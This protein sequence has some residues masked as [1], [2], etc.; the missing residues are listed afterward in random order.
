MM[1]IE[2]ETQLRRA[3]VKLLRETPEGMGSVAIATR[4]WQPVGKVIL[5]LGELQLTNNVIKN[6]NKNRW[7]VLNDS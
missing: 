4:L 1:K 3:I 7:F 5:A 2:N 6:E